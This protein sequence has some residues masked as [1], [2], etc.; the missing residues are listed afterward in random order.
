MPAA[1]MR[2]AHQEPV[3]HVL[4][5]RKIAVNRGDHRDSFRLLLPARQRSGGTGTCAG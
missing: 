4:P 5:V 2:I 3:A 1:V